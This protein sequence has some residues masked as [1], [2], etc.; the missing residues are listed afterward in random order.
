MSPIDF[1]I[2]DSPN[3]S[4]LC[5]ALRT[6]I[7]ARELFMSKS[8]RDQGLTT[9]RCINAASIGLRTDLSTL[10]TDVNIRDLALTIVAMVDQSLDLSL[11]RTHTREALLA[12]LTSKSLGDKLDLI[13]LDLTLDL[14]VDVM[15]QLVLRDPAICR[16]SSHSVLRCK[17]CKDLK[18]HTHFRDLRC[19]IL[20]AHRDLRCSTHMALR[21]PRCSTPS[22]SHSSFTKLLTRACLLTPLAEISADQA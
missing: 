18:D 19:S 16:C 3:I 7:E 20:T 11:L 10:N 13:S 6:L 14:S 17:S 21:D 4:D 5:S 8:T 2:S 15:D 22:L 9:V 12:T 1:Q